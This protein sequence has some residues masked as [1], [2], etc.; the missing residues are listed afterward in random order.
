[1]C[2]SDLHNRRRSSSVA[3]SPQ[4]S[5]EAERARAAYNDAKSHYVAAA[6]R[7]R[8]AE[9]VL[10]AAERASRAALRAARETA[11][12]DAAD[13]AAGLGEH[14]KPTLAIWR[15]WK[16]GGLYVAVARKFDVSPSQV[17]QIVEAIERIHADAP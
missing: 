17:R 7:L 9:A 10:F 12:S 8:E 5:S 16:A 14:T 6:D 4:P 13:A 11:R 3:N 2:S 1:V 15:A